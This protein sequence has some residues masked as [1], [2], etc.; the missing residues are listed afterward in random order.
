[1]EDIVMVLAFE[2]LNARGWDI[3]NVFF[4]NPETEFGALAQGDVQ[5]G[6]GAVTAALSSIQAGAKLKIVGEQQA[7][8]WAIVANEKVTSCD[9]LATTVFAV[10]SPGGTTTT[11]PL[12]WKETACSAEAA[13]AISPIYV[14]GS[15]NRAAALLAGEIDSTLLGPGDIAFL[16]REAP[17]RFHVLVDFSADASLDNLNSSVFVFTDE[18]LSTNVDAAAEILK[19]IAAVYA[20]AKADPSILAETAAAQQLTFG[21]AEQQVL[22]YQ[23]ETGTMDPNLSVTPESI[24][25]TIDYFVKY[26]GVKP[27][28][29]EDATVDLRPLELAGL[30]GG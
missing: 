25:F 29:V 21:D 17:G 23:L 19:E 11:F 27:G 13:A 1:L 28:L 5:M 2:R 7:V 22:R 3:E 18:Y 10:H 12:Y 9:D 8:P 30:T 26:G 16:E 14:E 20:E 15:E 4:S 6:A 24:A